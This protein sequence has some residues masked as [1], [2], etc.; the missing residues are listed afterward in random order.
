MILFKACTRCGGDVSA[1]YADDIFC[2]QCSYR[3]TASELHDV[4]ARVP[5]AGSIKDRRPSESAVA[6][7]SLAVSRSPSSTCPRCGS[8][9]LVRLERLR[10]RDNTCYRC[11][12]CGHIFSPTASY[13]SEGRRT[14]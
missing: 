12:P 7:V 2:I 6:K 13:E 14:G 8:T 11:R 5:N 1:T 10:Q 9:D 4:R 3:L